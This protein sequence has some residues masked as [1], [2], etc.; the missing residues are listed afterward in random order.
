MVNMSLISALEWLRQDDYESKATLG[1]TARPCLKKAN[2]KG[3]SSV[4]QW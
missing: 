1:Y 3:A 2:K 4:A